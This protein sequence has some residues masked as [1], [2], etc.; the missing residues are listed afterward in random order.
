MKFKNKN[1]YFHEGE[2]AIQEKNGVLDYW[3]DEAINSLVFDKINDKVRQFIESLPFFFI[4]TSDD[5]GNC[6]CSFRGIEDNE[7]SSLA[8][9][10]INDKTLVFPDFSGNN[11]FNSLGN[12][13]VN[14]HIGM[15]FMDFQRAMRVRLNGNVRL[16][17]D[18]TPYQDLW[19]TALQ[20]IE[21]NVE[22]LYPNCSQRIHASMKQHFSKGQ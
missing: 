2:L 10:V 15:L 13:Y 18:I 22:Q 14:P 1:D 11:L 9:K 20:V 8:V 3:T 16:L 17:E 19:P 4:S 6:D 7:T 21:V 12:M 5:N